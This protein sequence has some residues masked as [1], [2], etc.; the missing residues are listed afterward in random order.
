MTPLLIIDSLRN[1]VK[2]S[3][4]MFTDGKCFQLYLF[5]RNIYPHANAWYDPIVGHVYTEIDG[6]YYDIYGMHQYL[7]PK[8]YLLAENP[9]VNLEAFDWDYQFIKANGKVDGQLIET[10]ES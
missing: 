2:A 6:T 8:S 4:K 10:I 1:S 9:K 7:P 3:V 5:L